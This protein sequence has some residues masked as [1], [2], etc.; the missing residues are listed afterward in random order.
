[1]YTLVVNR[2]DKYIHPY[3]RIHIR[4]HVHIHRHVYYTD[5][6]IYIH[7]F[8]LIIILNIRLFIRSTNNENMNSFWTK[9]SIWR[10]FTKKSWN[11]LSS[12]APMATFLTI[13]LQTSRSRD[14][15]L[16]C[17]IHLR[18]AISML[19]IYFS[20]VHVSLLM[21][22]YQYM[23]D[24]DFSLGPYGRP[25]FMF[26]CSKTDLFVPFTMH[27]ILRYSYLVLWILIIIKLCT[28][29]T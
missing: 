5:I 3:L 2:R 9:W 12:A 24:R 6:Y 25:V 11:T 7:T 1:M 8:I 10:N 22:W 28:I 16:H 17:A 14:A 27:S 20:T 23:A 4:I 21:L 13:N 18:T 26:N 15:S 29:F 19:S